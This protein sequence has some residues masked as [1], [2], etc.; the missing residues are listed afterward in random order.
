[1]KNKIVDVS[2]V[3]IYIT[4]YPRIDK[5]FSTIKSVSSFWDKPDRI[6]MPGTKIDYEVY[7][8]GDG[9]TLFVNSTNRTDCD[10]Y[11]VKAMEHLLSTPNLFNVNGFREIRENKINALKDIF[12]DSGKE[13]I[14]LKQ[15]KNEFP[16]RIKFV[17]VSIIA[18]SIS[19]NKYLNFPKSVEMNVTTNDDFVITIHI[20]QNAFDMKEFHCGVRVN[21]GVISLDKDEFD[22]LISKVIPIFDNHDIESHHLAEEKLCNHFKQN[23]PHI[24]ND[25]S[26]EILY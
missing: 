12:K 11:F 14:F 16:P 24:C 1:M 23:L 21:D 5:I 15:D 2:R 18:D 25:Y 4:D 3:E 10:I 26:I 6:V 20:S 9:R 22:I 17:E 13:V 8:T 7:H 19:N